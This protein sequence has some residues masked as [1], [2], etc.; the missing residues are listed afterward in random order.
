MHSV[1]RQLKNIE[2]R[3]S[4]IENLARSRELTRLLECFPQ[5]H[6]VSSQYSV[7]RAFSSGIYMYFWPKHSSSTGADQRSRQTL[8]IYRHIL[9]VSAKYFSRLSTFSYSSTEHYPSFCQAM[10]KPFQLLTFLLNFKQTDNGSLIKC[11]FTEFITV[12]PFANGGL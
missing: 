8:L 5:N 9:P 12:L 7:C 10:R 6:S 3:N 1:S 4:I 2:W 11:I